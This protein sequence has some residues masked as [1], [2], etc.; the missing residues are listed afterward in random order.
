M[1][2]LLHLH[3]AGLPMK[4]LIL[5]S[6]V[7][8]CVSGCGTIN[9]TFTDDQTARQRLKAQGTRC[10]VI[11]RVYSGVAYDFCTLHADPASGPG[12]AGVAVNDVPVVLFDFLFSA[13]ADTFALPYTVYLQHRDGSLALR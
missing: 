11:P 13:V 9:S 4:R 1:V 10:E 7:T 8:A 6:L 2:S 5:A 3:A 12:P